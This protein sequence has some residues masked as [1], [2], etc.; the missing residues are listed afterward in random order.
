MRTVIAVLAICAGACQGAGAADLVLT[1]TARIGVFDED[2]RYM[3]GHIS[4]AA[5]LPDESIVVADYQVKQLRKYSEQGEFL[6]NV[7]HEGE[8]PGEYRDPRALMALPDGR[9][10]VLSR[11]SIVSFFDGTTCEY[12]D[13]F[14]VPSGLHAERLLEYDDD[15]YIYVRSIHEITN[16]NVEWAFKLIKVD[17]SGSVVGEV[18]IPLENCGT[19]YFV[20]MG[21][22]GMRRSFPTTTE[23]AWSPRGHLVVGRNDDYSFEIQRASGVI[24]VEQESQSIALRESEHGDWEATAA[25]MTRNSGES[26]SIPKSKPAFRELRVDSYGRVWVHRYVE[27]VEHVLLDQDGDAYSAWLEPNSYDVFTPDGVLLG[28]VTLPPRVKALA[29]S[30]AAIWG[31][32][33][34]DDGEQLVRWAI[35][36]LEA[37]RTP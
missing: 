21:A 4:H 23:A 24:H 7:G 5:V 20:L 10:V 27:A 29:W 1:E 2:A 33:R 9:L 16:P 18:D 3:F 37:V 22:E 36:G 26:Y 15:G 6:A 35:E 12:L 28:T 25:R 13:S 17:S 19:K 34:S 31:V 14:S 30:R 8:G 11:P 32:E